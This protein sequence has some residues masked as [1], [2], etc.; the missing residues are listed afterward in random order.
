M[1]KKVYGPA[2]EK[3]ME[4]SRYLGGCFYDAPPPF[5]PL[6]IPPTNASNF[7]PSRIRSR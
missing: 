4:E 7:Y 5:S 3:E 6:K 2:T 1:E